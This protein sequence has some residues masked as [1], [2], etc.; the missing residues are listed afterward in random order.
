M[1][2]TQPLPTDS[3]QSSVSDPPHSFLMGFLF[4]KIPTQAPGFT[5]LHVHMTHKCLFPVQLS[6]QCFR[7]THPIAYIVDITVWKSTMDSWFPSGKLDLLSGLIISEKK[8]S[9]SDLSPQIFPSET[10]LPVTR[11]TP[12]PPSPP[13]PRCQSKLWPGQWIPS[14]LPS[15]CSYPF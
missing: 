6:P 4:L 2:P 3:P 12:S 15:L 9:D 13:S 8:S 10:P 1:S 14:G 11:C 7:C 5:S